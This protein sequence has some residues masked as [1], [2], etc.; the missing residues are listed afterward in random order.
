MIFLRIHPWETSA[1]M[2]HAIV[3]RFVPATEAV[4]A[5]FPE[6]GPLVRLAAVLFAVIPEAV[7]TCPCGIDYDD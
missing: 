3:T 2:L 6:D 4:L 1:P 7:G 5:L